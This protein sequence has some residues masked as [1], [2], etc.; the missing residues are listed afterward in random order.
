[1]VVGTLAEILSIVLGVL[2]A[3]MLAGAVAT[4]WLV[5]RL[6][7]PLVLARGVSFPLRWRWSLARQAVLHRR[8]VAAL[9]GVRLSLPAGSAGGPWADLA[10]DLETL[11]V[12]VDRGLVAVDRQP[13][14]VRVRALADLEGRVREVEQVAG[15]LQASLADRTEAIGSRT[16]PEIVARLELIERA[17]AELGEGAGPPLAAPPAAPDAAGSG[18]RP[19]SG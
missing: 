5:R 9:A 17:M 1:M 10:G 19:A 6:R 14:P 18:P 3:L 8:L 7:A 12:E 13:R 11:A 4:A 16:G 15:R 2:A